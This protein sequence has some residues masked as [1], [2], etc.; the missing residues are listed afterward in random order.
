[1]RK[2]NEKDFTHFIIAASWGNLTVYSLKS[3]LT[4]WANTKR[5]TL[6]GIKPDGSRAILDTK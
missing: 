3:A 6:Y 4:E 1:M 5:G 2:I